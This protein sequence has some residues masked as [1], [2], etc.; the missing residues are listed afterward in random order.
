MNQRPPPDPCDVLAV[1]PKPGGK[2]HAEIRLTRGRGRVVRYN[3]RIWVLDD[4]GTMRPTMR[5]I[6]FGE[7]KL[8]SVRDALVEACK[9]AGVD[10]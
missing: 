5:G 9:V 7:D 6:A 10:D 3:L 1:V 8:T 4:D 2:R